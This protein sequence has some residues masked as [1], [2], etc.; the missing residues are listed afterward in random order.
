M[1][2][3]LDLG[4]LDGPVLVFGGPYGNLQATTAMRAK[5]TALGIPPQRTLCTGDLVAYCAAPQQSVDVIRD[6]NITVVQ[7]NCEESLG[8]GAPDCGCGFEEGSACDA[9]SDA[10][11]TFADAQL[12]PTTK[13]WM[14]TRPKTVSFTLN[15]ARLAVVHGAPSNISRFVFA[16]TPDSDVRAE[17]DR[18]AVDAIIGGHCGLPFS[19]TLPDG[20]LWLGAGV[21]GMPANDGTPRVWYAVLTPTQDGIDISRQALTYDHMGAAADMA[22][23]GLPNAYAQCLKTGL[24]PNLDILPAAERRAQGVALA[25]STTLWQPGADQFL[26]AG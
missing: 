5:A 21:I 18:L 20:R 8:A 2:D 22:A 7:G 6:W 16:S 24:W 15:G 17:I 1:V 3:L 11:Y 12:S 13:T 9:L 10:W 23:N 25:P 4:T 14:A 26:A 19:R